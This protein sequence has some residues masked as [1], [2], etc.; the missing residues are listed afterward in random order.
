MASVAQTPVPN[1]QLIEAEDE[2]LESYWHVI[3]I[4]L[5]I[6]SVRFHFRDR[7]NYFAG[8]NV[9]VYYSEVQARNRDF[10]GPDFFFV[11]DVDGQKPRKWWV[12]WE[13]DGR[14][15]DMILEFLSPTTAEIDRTVK[16]RLYERTFR[17]PEYFCYDPDTEK[18]EGWRLGEKSRYR[19]IRPDERGWLWCETLQLWLGLWTGT[20]LGAT[21]A[22]PRFYTA[23]G[24]LVPTAAEAEKQRAE[25]ERQRAEA[26][27][28]RA[29][30]AEARLARRRARS[31]R[32]E[33]PTPK[34]D[35]GE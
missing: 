18:L 33:T 24:E 35:E 13:E 23:E 3:A 31:A 34:P 11:D 1:I 5:L 30:Q 14:Y 32:R 9:F 6:D 15:P 29:D 7:T 20:H 25:A 4:V 19:S 12:V 27:K 26:E 22:F 28:R 21:G 10:R 8:G 17:T 16:K 2:P